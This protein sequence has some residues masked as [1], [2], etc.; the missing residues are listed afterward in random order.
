MRISEDIYIGLVVAFYS[1][2][3][4]VDEDNTS[5]RSIN[6]SFEIHMLPFDLVHITNTPYK[7]ILCRGGA[8]WWQ[9]LEVT[10]EEVSEFLTGRKDMQV[11]DIL[12]STLLSTIR[13]VYS[14]VQYTVLPKIGKLML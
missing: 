8:K 7:G 14:I 10:K 4:P 5:L 9:Q 13:A 11:R 12:T 1:T 3:A 6:G 2:L